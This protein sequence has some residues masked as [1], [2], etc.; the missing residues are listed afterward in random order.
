MLWLLTSNVMPRWGYCQ[1]ATELNLNHDGHVSGS[2]V[3]SVTRTRMSC[4][5]VTIAKTEFYYHL[6]ILRQLHAISVSATRRQSTTP[7]PTAS[8]QE[9]LVR[10]SLEKP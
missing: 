10:T 9:S 6:L 8:K 4:F 3:L 5:R 7:P 1:T 2:Q